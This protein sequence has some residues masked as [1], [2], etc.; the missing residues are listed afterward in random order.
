MVPGSNF[1]LY[2]TLSCIW[3]P[4]E[5]ALNMEDLNAFTLAIP[6]EHFSQY[7]VVEYDIV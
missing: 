1:V 7:L 3:I 4:T 5:A 2:S 6:Q